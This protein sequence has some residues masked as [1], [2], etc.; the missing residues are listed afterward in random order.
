[1]RW[2]TRGWNVRVLRSQLVEEVICSF[3]HVEEN[4]R[5]QFVS[6]GR[7]SCIK[8][9]GVPLMPGM[10]DLSELCTDLTRSWCE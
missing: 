9:L 2:M 8:P 1:M 6:D 3:T 7:G 10:I 5:V 4:Q